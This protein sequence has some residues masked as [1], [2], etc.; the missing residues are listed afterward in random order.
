MAK[1]ILTVFTDPVEGREDEYNLWYSEQ[2]I[3]DL[4]KIPAV[5]RAVRYEVQPQVG[6]VHDGITQRYLAIY[7]IETDDLNAVLPAIRALGDSGEM[8]VSDA[9]ARPARLSFY[10]QIATTDD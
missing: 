10:S 2:H 4:L 1:H 3:H 7:E 5:T 6:E 9:L 8:P